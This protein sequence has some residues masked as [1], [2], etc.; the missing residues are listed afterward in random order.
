VEKVY[1]SILQMMEN[2]GRSLANFIIKQLKDLDMSKVLIFAGSGGNGGGGIC[3]VRHL[4]NHGID[5]SY[6]ISQYPDSLLGAAKTQYLILKN[7][8]SSPIMKENLPQAISESDMIIDALIGYSLKGDP[9]GISKVFIDMINRSGKHV[10]SLDIP[11]GIDASTGDEKNPFVRADE[12]LTLA[13]PKT[14]LKNLNTGDLYL[15]DIGIPNSVYSKLDIEFE[16]F[17][18]EEYIIPIYRNEVE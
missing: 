13:L 10:I 4:L 16:N 18:G 14:G 2:A 5:A 9:K 8:G 6:I 7:S 15:A 11:S 12:T 3:A 1:L 17:F